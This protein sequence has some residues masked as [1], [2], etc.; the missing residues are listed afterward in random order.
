MKSIS[1]F[2]DIQKS[3]S[4]IWT[5]NIYSQLTILVEDFPQLLIVHVV[6]KVFNIDIGELLCT[7]SQFSLP[8][9]P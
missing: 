9:L 7:G 2:A 5:A 4:S 8:L 3:Q 1:S 6:T